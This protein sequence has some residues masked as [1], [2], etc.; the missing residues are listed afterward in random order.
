VFPL[1]SYKLQILTVGVEH[2]HLHMASRQGGGEVEVEEEGDTV[3]TEQ[4]V[5]LNIAAV[6][7]E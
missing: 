3:D 6:A 1:P 7:T 2:C 4:L 5:L